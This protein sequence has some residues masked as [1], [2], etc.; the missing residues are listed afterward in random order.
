MVDVIANSTVVYIMM[1]NPVII[2][3]EHEGSK[4]FL[5]FGKMLS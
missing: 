3:H 1:F 2:R 5:K 4:I